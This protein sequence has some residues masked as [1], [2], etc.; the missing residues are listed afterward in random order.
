MGPAGCED[1]ATQ[2]ASSGRLRSRRQT[3]LDVGRTNRGTSAR[4]HGRTTVE[5]MWDADAVELRKG[6][7]DDTGR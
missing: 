1:I 7:A 2:P 6:A 5:G 3:I 4:F